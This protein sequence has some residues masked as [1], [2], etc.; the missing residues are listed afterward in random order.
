[1]AAFLAAIE[2]KQQKS[3]LYRRRRET[4]QAS[5]APTNKGKVKKWYAPARPLQ[6]STTPGKDEIGEAGESP[7]R[8]GN[9]WADV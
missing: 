5:G 6:R 4:V 9:R 8:G 2:N 7:E 1:M 3:A